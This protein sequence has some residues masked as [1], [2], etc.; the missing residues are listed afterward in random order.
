[1]IFHGI[2]QIGSGMSEVREGMVIVFMGACTM[3][4][5]FPGARPLGGVVLGGGLV[6]IAYNSYKIR[7]GFKTI[8]DALFVRNITVDNV[9]DVYFPWR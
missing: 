6:H 4:V 2:L 7:G 9:F 5:P 1:M 3:A 8:H